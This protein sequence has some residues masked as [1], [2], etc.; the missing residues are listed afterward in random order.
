M[1]E[2]TNKI[3]LETGGE[4]EL[5]T[6]TYNTRGTG[7]GKDNLPNIIVKGP[8]RYNV[9][10]KRLTG[11]NVKSHLPRKKVEGLSPID[12]AFHHSYKLVVPE[13]KIEMAI[14]EAK[15]HIR[16]GTEAKIRS[17]RAELEGM[18]VRLS[19]ILKDEFEVKNRLH[20]DD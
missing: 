17:L 12:G 6:V 3:E 14:D 2:Q 19:H 16:G 8:Y 7:A 5:C 20:D 4:I 15:A 1:T 13:S 11:L 9:G 10:K 18:E